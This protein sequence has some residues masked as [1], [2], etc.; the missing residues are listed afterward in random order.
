M[1]VKLDASHFDNQMVLLASLALMYGTVA[2]DDDDRGGPTPNK[3]GTGGNGNTGGN[4]KQFGYFT[5]TR[6]VFTQCPT[7]WICDPV[8]N[9]SG[10]YCM[11]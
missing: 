2:C 3:D 5:K 6:T 8:N 11:K 7:F 4:G 1:E 9:A 10:M